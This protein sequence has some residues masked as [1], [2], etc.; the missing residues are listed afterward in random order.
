MAIKSLKINRRNQE[1]EKNIILKKPEDIPTLITPDALNVLIEGDENPFYGVQAIRYP[2]DGNGDIYE[3]SFFESFLEKNKE[4]PFPGDKY[5]HSTSWAKRQNTD[6]YQIGGEVVPDSPGSTEG[7]V[8]FKFYVPAESD[9]ESNKGFIAEWRTNALDLSLVSSVKEQYRESDGKWHITASMGSQRNDAVNH[10]GGSMEQIVTN[11]KKD[12]E[13]TETVTELET[14]I[15]NLVKSGELDV[16][17][18]MKNIGKSDLLKSNADIENLKKYNSL[19]GVLGDNPVEAAKKLQQTVKEN[20]ETV[21]ES[22]MKTNF[23]EVLQKDGKTKNSLREL[24]DTLLNNREL[25]LEVLEE[26]KNNSLVKRELK[27][28]L[29]VRGNGTL[30][31]DGKE[32]KVNAFKEVDGVTIL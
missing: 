25:T 21:K 31:E 29:D 26:L 28:N 12:N 17:N 14:K 9:R 24:A 7:T 10:G 11:N 2:V 1:T 6:F 16:E 13:E 18:F 3:S 5:G 32:P 4:F 20:A 19:V 23:G 27:S 22:T 15:N 8:Y 30:L